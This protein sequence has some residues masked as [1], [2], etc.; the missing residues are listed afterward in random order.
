MD[1]DAID[2]KILRALQDN[3]RMTTQELAEK[4]GLSATPCARRVKRM[5]DEGLIARYVTLL[6]PAHLGLGLMVFISVRLNTQA[7]KAFDTFEAEIRKLPEVVGCFLLAGS[8]D[9]LVQVRVANVDAFR[10]FIRDHL[11]T[12]EGVAE[13]QSS[14]VLE[15]TKTTTALPIAS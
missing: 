13:T 4:V 7:A 1:I 8:Y 5:E 14:I 2:R 11:V 15:E 6:N 3:A 9:Y 12:I 10:N